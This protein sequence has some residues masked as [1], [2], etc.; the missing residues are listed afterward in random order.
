MISFALL[1]QVPLLGGAWKRSA[2][3]VGPPDMHIKVLPKPV[4]RLVRLPV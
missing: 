2:K 1:F 4:G 3:E